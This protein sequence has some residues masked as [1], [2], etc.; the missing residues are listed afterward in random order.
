M[1]LVF[2]THNLG[3]VR[4]LR[5][6]VGAVQVKSLRDFPELAPVEEDGAT[7]LATLQKQI[8]QR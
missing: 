7:F 8:N 1:P 6:L 3:K 4:E 5:S 2:A